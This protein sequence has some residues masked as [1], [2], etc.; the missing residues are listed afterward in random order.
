[1]PQVIAWENP[2]ENEIVWKYP[3]EEIEWGAQLV[4]RENEVAVFYR[5]GKVYAVF[6]AGRHTLTTLN[7]PV[8]EGLAKLGFGGK[9]PFRATVIFVSLKRFQGKF[10]GRAQTRELAPIQFHGTFWYEVK[11]ASVFVNK[12]VG[13]QSL[14]TTS[15]LDKYLRGY[16]NERAMKNLSNYTLLDVYQNLDRVTKEITLRLRED[17]AELG[18]H[19]V[20][21]KFEG[22]DVTDPK[23]RDRL[24][25]LLTG[26]VSAQSVLQM[27]TV[28]DVAESL[29]KSPG[30]GLGAGMMII[31]PLFQQPTQQAQ[32]AAPAPGVVAGQPPTP[33][34]TPG[35]QPRCPNC[36]QPVPQ[37]ANFCPNCGY[38]LK[39]CPNGHVVPQDAKFC[40]VCGAQITQ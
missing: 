32:P 7:F 21:V 34:G 13:A 10:G 38:K 29:G 16:F 28:A 24:F 6:G 26:R 35:Y 33:P 11:D 40:P 23:W 14:Y 3:S 30:A 15:E 39:W 36:G 27:E 4:V 19:I 1:M 9:S 20:D 22:I 12:V 18:L 8:L 2:G 5:D 37:G 31:P 25:W 17:F